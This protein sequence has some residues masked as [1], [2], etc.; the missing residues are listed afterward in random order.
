MDIFM[1]DKIKT[2]KAP[3]SGQLGDARPNLMMTDIRQMTDVHDIYDKYRC[4]VNKSG[5]EQQ[6]NKKIVSEFP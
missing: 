6:T 2:L 3:S 5:K 1:S 4:L